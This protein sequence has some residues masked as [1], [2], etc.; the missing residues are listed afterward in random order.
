MGWD[1]MGCGG[2]SNGMRWDVMG[3]DGMRWDEVG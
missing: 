1:E 3:W 2:I